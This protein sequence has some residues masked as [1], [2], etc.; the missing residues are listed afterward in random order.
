AQGIGRGICQYLLHQE[1]RVVIADIDAEAGRECLNAFREHTER[2]RFFLTDVGDEAAVLACIEQTL[3]TFRRIDGLVNNAGIA[4]PDAGPVEMLALGDWERVIRT[5]LTGAF[6]MTK[7]AAPHLRASRGAIVNIASTRA[8]QSEK[9]SE[10]YAASKGGLVAL[11][12][13]LAV[14][15]GPEVRV[16]C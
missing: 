11:T 8:L 1:Y 14:S 2:L 13:A 4:H 6:L 10:A 15:L 9:D 7:H 16:N 12:H 5:N 3:G